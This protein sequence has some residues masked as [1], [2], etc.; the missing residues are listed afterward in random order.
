MD[1][2]SISSTLDLICLDSSLNSSSDAKSTS[3]LL[4]PPRDVHQASSSSSS[5]SSSILS[6][7]VSRSSHTLSAENIITNLKY[8]K[9]NWTIVDVKKKK[10]ECWKCFGIPAF[11]SDNGNAEM[12]D[13]FVSCKYCYTTYAYSSSTRNMIKHTETCD[14]FNP[15]Q[16]HFTKT[17]EGDSS[18]GIQLSN[19][20]SSSPGS[21]PTNN[22]KLDSHKHKMNNLLVE[23]ICSSIRPLNIVED[24][25]FKKLI[26]EAIHIGTSFVE[27]CM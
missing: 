12:F 27:T 13:K 23:W 14:G 4:S 25:G 17:T 5:S 26:E 20:S 1:I 9:K 15:K 21:S 10:S 6:F 2:P 19:Q 7:D 16:V 22:K 8:N 24:A 3:S 11:K 18:Q